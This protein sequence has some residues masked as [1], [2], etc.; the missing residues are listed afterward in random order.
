MGNSHSFITAIVVIG[1]GLVPTTVAAIANAQMMGPMA[2]FCNAVRAGVATGPQA[3][4][5]GLLGQNQ[6]AQPPIA[7]N[8]AGG[9]AFPC[10]FGLTFNS[11]IGQCVPTGTATSTTNG[12]CGVNS[13]LQNGVCIPIATTTT[14]TPPTA[15]A[16]PD[17]TVA[18]NSTVILNGAG[19]AATTLG[20]TITGYS[21]TQTAGPAVSLTGANT[22]T[23]TFLAPTVTA[24][25]ELTFSLT[26]TDSN[27]QISSPSFTQV[28]VN[29]R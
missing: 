9:T 21:W 8:T 7:P 2:S 13:I 5:C 22:V 26:V 18:E 1:A 23:P 25:T 24:Q 28:N 14:Q 27:G 12:V 20:A 11:Q 3:G 16:G 6:L 15:N 10:S 4:I 29:P 19:S 17:Q